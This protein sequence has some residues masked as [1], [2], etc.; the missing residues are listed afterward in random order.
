MGQKLCYVVFPQEDPSETE[1]LTAS[2]AIDWA[3]Q[4]NQEFL[5]YI[6]TC[7]SSFCITVFYIG[8]FV[9]GEEMVS[10]MFLHRCSLSGA[11]M[12]CQ[13]EA[14]GYTWGISMLSPKAA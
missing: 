11:V 12:K 5:F 1:P 9:D 4:S 10:S 6:S 13:K 14:D 2:K 3:V 8:Q 7:T